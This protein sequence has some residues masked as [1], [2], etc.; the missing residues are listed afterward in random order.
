MILIDSKQN[1]TF[2]SKILQYENFLE[3]KMIE[4]RNALWLAPCLFTFYRHFGRFWHMGI[5]GK[6]GK[7]LLTHFH[8][9]HVHVYNDIQYITET[10]IRID[11]PTHSTL[12]WFYFIRH[13]Q[14]ES[15]YLLCDNSSILF[16]D[17]S[18]GKLLE[19]STA[20]TCKGG[21]HQQL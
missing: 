11:Y 14:F 19:E 10:S 16:F 1:S 17:S 12:F 6:F 18:D 5:F 9:M 4:L 15:M 20:S 21:C 3:V 7:T 8:L 13:S 2:S